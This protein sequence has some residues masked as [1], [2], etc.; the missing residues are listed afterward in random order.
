M[1]NA[2]NRVFSGGT[3]NALPPTGKKLPLLPPCRPP[4]AK[5]PLQSRFHTGKSHLARFLLNI[6]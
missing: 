3:G 5:T 1:E 2:E 6:P 4:D